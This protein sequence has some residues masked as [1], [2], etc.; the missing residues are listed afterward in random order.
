MDEFLRDVDPI[1]EY[2]PISQD[3]AQKGDFEAENTQ[4]NTTEYK[5]VTVD[6]ADDD[7]TFDAF[8]KAQNTAPVYSQPV[9]PTPP[10]APTPVAPS[11]TPPYTAPQPQQVSQPQYVPQQPQNRGYAPYQPASPA[12]QQQTYQA[13]RAPY[14]PPKPAQPANVQYTAPQAPAY[15]QQNYQ[16]ANNPQ[17]QPPRQAVSYAQPNPYYTPQAPQTPQPPRAKTPTRTKVLIGIL[18]GLLA[19]FMLSFFVSC[20]LLTAGKT[21]KLHFDN[22][23]SG[24][25]T[26]PEYDEFYDDYGTSPYFDFGPSYQGD[27]FKEDVVLQADEGQTQER[28]EDLKNNTYAPDKDAK[29]INIKALPKDK[30]SKKYTTQSAY[31]AVTDSVVSVTCYEDK[32]TLEDED[33]IGEGTGTVISSDGYIVTNSHVIGDTKAYKI[34]VT[35]NNGDDYGAKVVG[36]DTRTDLAVLKI[37][38]KNLSYAEFSDSSLVEVGQDIVAIGN[39]GGSSFQNSLTKGI[40]SAVERELDLGANV[41]YIQIDAAINPGNSGGPL[42]NIY[43]QVIGINTAKISAEEYEGMGFAIPSNKVA[44]IAND[45]IH[46]GFVKDR[47]RLGLMGREVDE[48]MIYSYDVPY[49]ILI[50]EISE[51]GPLDNTDIELF[52]IITEINGVE[53]TTF[54]EVFS[55][56]EKYKPG[57]EVTLTLYRLEE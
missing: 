2:A 40:V 27:Y 36:Y 32:I 34:N 20:S 9:P 45:L 35:L 43:G 7:D 54:Q 14:Q 33:I 49:G 57:D 37:D 52:D 1:D 30:D 29:G 48:E 47:V 19:V 25:A 50:T 53:V 51:G 55:E 31:N 11:Y 15:S 12:Q 23:L 21:D 22:P 5:T 17:Q 18:I 16:Y 13:P 39:P 56:L 38:A 24:Y 46:Y 6:T 41:T 8:D 44:Q 28:E 26:E 10:V 42:C 3:N 4:E